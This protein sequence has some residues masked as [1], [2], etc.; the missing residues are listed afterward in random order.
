MRVVFE[1]PLLLRTA[2]FHWQLWAFY[3]VQKPVMAIV[4]M[5]VSCLIYRH[6]LTMVRPTHK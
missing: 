5:V 4:M 2:I 1:Y 6:L 3:H